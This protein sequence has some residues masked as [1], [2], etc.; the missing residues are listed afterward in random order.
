[1]EPVRGQTGSRPALVASPGRD[2]PQTAG[3]A[4]PRTPVTVGRVPLTDRGRMPVFDVL[5]VA[6]A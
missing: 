3:P 6:Y 1:M 5:T 2:S 4:G